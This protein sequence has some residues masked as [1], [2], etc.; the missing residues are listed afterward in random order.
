MEG[1]D[2]SNKYSHLRYVDPDISAVIWMLMYSVA[3]YILIK[4]LL[5]L[6]R[7]MLAIGFGV[8]DVI[9][10]M[11]LKMLDLAPIWMP[12]WASRLSWLAYGKGIWTSPRWFSACW[13]M[14]VLRA[15]ME[16]TAVWHQRPKDLV[17]YIP[18]QT[19]KRARS[20]IADF[21][22]VSSIGARHAERRS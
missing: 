6:V 18:I 13:N 2:G 16:M 1:G 10:S 4:W 8:V 19:F 9:F 3:I 7:T 22:F 14:Q 12:S 20:Q 21:S 5:Y 15:V 11:A 17:H